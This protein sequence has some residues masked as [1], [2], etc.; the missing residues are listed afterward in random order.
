MNHAT[1]KLGDYKIPLIG[2]PANA[3]REF[4]DLCAFEGELL[5]INLAENGRQFLC[6]RCFIARK[7]L[8]TTPNK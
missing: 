4:C 2:V 6:D 1:V 8:L 3:T 5:E 7:L